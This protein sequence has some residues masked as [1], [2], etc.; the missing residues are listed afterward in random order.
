MQENRNRTI[1]ETFNARLKTPWVWLIILLTLGLTALFYFSQRP[2]VVMYSRYIKSLSDY[3]LMDMDLMRSMD[4]VRCGF[5]ADSVKILSQGMSLRELAV[6]FSKDMDELASHGVAT[7]PGYAVSGFERRVLSKVAGIHRYMSVRRAWFDSLEV[8]YRE[9]ASYPG[10]MS[11][12]VLSALDSARNGF[13]VRVPADVEFPD[14]LAVRLLGLMNENTELALAWSQF[15]NHTSILASEE[16]IQFFQSESLKEIA[17]KS[18]IPLVFYFLS[19]VLLLSTFFF[20]FK[21]KS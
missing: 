5:A 10:E 18:K 15:D 16:L 13:P 4:R 3:Q 8:L 12:P 20:I 14:T 19:L 6:S 11:Y 17:L 2:G 9:V 21:S 1:A 7:P